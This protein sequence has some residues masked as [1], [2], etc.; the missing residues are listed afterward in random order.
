M[1]TKYLNIKIEGVKNIEKSEFTLPF[2][3]GIYTLVGA[4]GCG[5][6]TIL[7]CISQ[8]IA[9]KVGL[10]KLTRHDVRQNAFVE[11]VI[12]QKKTRWT[13]NHQDS[14]WSR[15]GDFLKFNGLYE[16][17]LFYGTRFEDS[18]KI[19]SLIS[20]NKISES[21]ITDA[22]D[23]VKDKMSYILH[24]NYNHYRTLKRIKN[25]QTAESIGV[26]N[27]PYFIAMP[28]GLVSQYRMSSGECLLVSLLHFLY[29]SI[30]R[31]SLSVDQDVL[32]IIDELELALHP[33]AISRLIEYLTELVESHS[34][35]I[36]YLSSHSPEVIRSIS[37]RN[38]FKIENI[39]GSIYLQNNCYPSYLIRDLYSNVS[40]DCLL[41]VEDRL[42][43]IFVEN[44]LARENLRISKL[45]HCVPVGGWQ[46]VLSLHQE[47][48]T[49]KILGSSAYIVSILDG[50]IETELT[51]NQKKLPHLFLPIASI[52]KFMY[53]IAIRNKFPEIRRRVNDNFFLVNS[54]D[55]IISE[56]N[57]DPE[58]KQGDK[59]FYKY[60]TSELKR[61]GTLEESFVKGL[62]DI[63]IDEL[64]CSRFISSLRGSIEGIASKS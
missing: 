50:D 3:N 17:S 60:I 57:Q 20:Q 9:P 38:M 34:N 49:K 61:I 12:G 56:Y 43:Q 40:P 2:M 25:K 15:S 4:N 11:F 1:G 48:Y 37:P 24:G 41:L 14:S 53:D 7:Q 58:R 28:G 21:E 63:T 8:L 31:R 52:E 62:C 46:N 36:I 26:K 35:L 59:S 6:S 45:I 29:N 18:T 30:V 32:V 22:D 33:I 64:N 19:E 39:S 55:E 42:S 54:L 47:L 44:I 10:R 5:K 27:R 23:D 13:F 16:G 51:K